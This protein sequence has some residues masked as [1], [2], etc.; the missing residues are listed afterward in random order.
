MAGSDLVRMDRPAWAKNVKMSILR[1][2]QYQGRPRQP[3][4]T[5][6]NRRLAQA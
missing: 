2:E 3:A 6:A 1:T 5:L 4:G